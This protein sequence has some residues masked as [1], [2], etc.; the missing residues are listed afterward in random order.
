MT[1]GSE[2][3]YGRAQNLPVNAQVIKLVKLP[4]KL[5]KKVDNKTEHTNIVFKKFQNSPPAP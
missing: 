5:V 3:N 2:I 1:A 4:V